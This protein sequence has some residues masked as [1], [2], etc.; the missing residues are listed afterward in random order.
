MYS[1][2]HDIK[3]R[4]WW[5]DIMLKDQ[6]RWGGLAVTTVWPHCFPKQFPFLA[7]VTR[8]CRTESKVWPRVWVR[9]ASV[10]LDVE[11]SVWWQ[12]NSDRVYPAFIRGLLGVCLARLCLWSHGTSAAVADVG[13][14][15]V[16]VG[17]VLGPCLPTS[18]KP[19]VQHTTHRVPVF[20]SRKWPHSAGFK[21]VFRRYKISSNAWPVD[22]GLQHM[23]VVKNSQEYAHGGQISWLSCPPPSK[24]T[25]HTDKNY[26]ISLW[27][28]KVDLSGEFRSVRERGWIMWTPVFPDTQ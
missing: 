23:P 2:I 18:V 8:V 28:I 17:S 7:S 1:K 4:P 9:A 14:D 16:W 10:V 25:V 12:W 15:S 5:R 24:S 27:L 20:H 13:N 11:S 3:A 6:Q 26:S 22:C 21:R 19:G